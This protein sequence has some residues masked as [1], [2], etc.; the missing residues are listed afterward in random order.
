MSRSRL[1]TFAIEI[2]RRVD[3]DNFQAFID[4]RNSSTRKLIVY[5]KPG[6]AIPPRWGFGMARIADLPAAEVDSEILSSACIKKN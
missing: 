2:W 3:L 4:R 6:L 5:L 1:R